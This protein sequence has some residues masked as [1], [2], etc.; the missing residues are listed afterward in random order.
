MDLDA[1]GHVGWK[2][3]EVNETSNRTL[4]TICAGIGGFDKGFEEAGWKTT[5]QIELDDVN[6]TV[7]ADLFPQARQHRDLRDWRSFALSPVGCVAFG[8]PC[9]DISNMATAKRDQSKRGLAGER[10]GL[11]FEIMACVAALKPAWVVVENVPALLYIND[12]RDFQAVIAELSKCGYVGFWR[13]LDSQ[14]FGIPQKRRRLL[15][16]AGLGRYPSSEFLS[17]ARPVESLPASPGSNWIAKQA[18]SWAGYTLT[19][20]N[21]FNRCSSR[22]N[23]GS[24]LFVAEEDGWGSMVERAREVEVHGLRCGLDATNLEEAYAAGNAFPPPMA[25]WIAEILNRS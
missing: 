17:D 6:R 15:L 10:S 14:Y 9:Q 13:V 7:L 11:F 19:A 4:G 22:I 12:C 18:D 3:G 8:F 21:K 2:G 24:E 1:S 25:N 23:L 5:W 16:V 20:P